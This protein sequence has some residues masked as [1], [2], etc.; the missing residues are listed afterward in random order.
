[1]ENLEFA[2]SKVSKNPL[3]WTTVSVSYITSYI[4]FIVSYNDSCM[5]RAILLYIWSYTLP[6]DLDCKPTSRSHGR[7]AKVL[8]PIILI[9]FFEALCMITVNT[10]T[11]PVHLHR[12]QV[13]SVSQIMQK[14]KG[15]NL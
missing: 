7:A 12:V 1:M 2:K 14:D 10:C 3:Y 8:A 4:K 11:A 13:T 5:K 9:G 15:N 6:T